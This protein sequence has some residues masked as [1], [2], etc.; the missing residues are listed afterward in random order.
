MSG[1]PR[2]RRGVGECI[3]KGEVLCIY[4]VF[5]VNFWKI[6]VLCNLNLCGR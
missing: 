2:V 1:G 5:E 3:L 4:M 6:Y